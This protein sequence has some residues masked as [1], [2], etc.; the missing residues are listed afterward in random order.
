MSLT[1]KMLKAMGI[2]EEKI[3]QIIEAHMESV[4]ALK[5]ARDE[6]K[7]KVDEIPALEEKIKELAGKNAEDWKKKYE[8][9][10]DEF[11]GYKSEIEKKENDSAKEKAVRDYFE[12]KNITGKNLEIAMRGSKAE[13]EKIEIKNGK[14]KD[15]SSLDELISGDF[16]ALV[17]TTT[18]TGANTATP[19]TSSASGKDILS[20]DDIRKIKD[21]GER[22]K[23]WEQYLVQQN[24]ESKEG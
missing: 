10:S 22:R 2:E 11:N 5:E 24:N 6:L 13:I 18:T 15:A 20:R 4:N 14:I 8:E 3:E 9:L 1:R 23:A 12:K 16:S 7:D 19:P 17:S 21:T